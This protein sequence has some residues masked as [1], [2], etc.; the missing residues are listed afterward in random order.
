MYETVIEKTS[1]NSKHSTFFRIFISYLNF[2]FH[3]PVSYNTPFH[4]NCD[5][6]HRDSELHHMSTLQR[7]DLSSC[8]V[9]KYIQSTRSSAH[10]VEQHEGEEVF[11][12]VHI[13]GVSRL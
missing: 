13:Q 7:A 3:L 12:I 8:H 9:C 4:V 10:H 1:L 11:S 2:S 6:S 5:M